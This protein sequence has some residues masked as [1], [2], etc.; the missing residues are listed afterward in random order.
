MAFFTSKISFFE[1]IT[2]LFS[3]MAVICSIVNVFPSISSEERM[4][5]ILFFFLN[6]VGGLLRCAEFTSPIFSKM[7]ETNFNI[8]PVILWSNS[9][10]IHDTIKNNAFASVSN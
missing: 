10:I 3:T 6:S 4:V 9:Y 5:L 2:L 8:F 1:P 7:A